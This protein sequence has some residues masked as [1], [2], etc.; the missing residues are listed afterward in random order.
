MNRKGYR[1]TYDSPL[2]AREEML[3]GELDTQERRTARRFPLL[4]HSQDTRALGACAF[5]PR[6][7][8]LEE[9]KEEKRFDRFLHYE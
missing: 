4:F 1:T 3:S 8:F 5:T 6:K 2:A 9:S 7:L